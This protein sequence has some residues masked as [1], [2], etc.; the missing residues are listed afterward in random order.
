MILKKKNKLWNVCEPDGKSVELLSNTCNISEFLS[1]LLCSRG[2]T[3]PENAAS[4]LNKET[5]G[6]H[7]PFLLNDMD[8]AV[9]RINEALEKNEK[10][11]IYGDYDVDGLTSVSV[12]YLYLK[13]R[14]AF[15]DYYIPDRITEGYGLNISAMDKIKDS[16]TSLIITVDSGITAIEEIKY[17]T[18]FGLDVVITDHHECSAELPVCCAA[19]N[20][21]RNDCE[22]PFKE[23]AGVGVVFK[24][25]CALE[26]NKNLKNVLK[27]YSSLTA[28]GTIADVMPLE[29]ENRLIAHVGLYYLNNAPTV[30]IECLVNEIFSEK[31]K[32]NKG[33]INSSVIGFGIAP[34]INA[35]GRIGNAD[36]AATLLMS[37]TKAEA[38]RFARL[39]C[40]MNVQRQ[41]IE[42]DIFEEAL[43]QIESSFD[44]ENDRVIVLAGDGWHT[45]VIG[46]VASK[47]VEKYNLPTV[48]LSFDG[49]AGKGS[50]RSIKGFNIVE[51]FSKTKEYLTRFGGH[52]LAAGVSIDRKNLDGFVKAI[53][54]YAKTVFPDNMPPICLD[55]DFE[56]SPKYLN[57]DCAQEIEKLEPFG[58][59]NPTPVF[60]L[61][62]VYISESVPIT[63]GKHIR[64][65]L[66]KDGVKIN[67]MCF[68]VRSM[69][70]SFSSGLKVDCLINLS[71]NEF[72]NNRTAQVIIRDIDFADS[73]AEYLSSEETKYIN[74]LN[75]IVDKGYEIPCLN[76]FKKVFMYLRALNTESPLKLSNIN[77]L[78][79]SN[80][81]SEKYDIG[82]SPCDLN[83]IFDVL[84]EM[85]IIKVI[86][87]DNFNNLSVEILPTEGKVNLKESSILSKL[88][89]P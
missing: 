84:H 70:F 57:L 38:V 1:K 62:D 4:F 58:S 39:L 73:V 64:L 32:D 61:K 30:G 86:R 63:D 34:R 45:G 74:A 7:D 75:G 13:S 82:I 53:N 69:D 54:Q 88:E 24:L 16:G 52:E 37:E 55:A 79:A 46:I 60:Y 5:D 65:V 27:N 47:I 41:K 59:A 2:F 89:N 44:F 40:E 36:I 35:A 68:N 83:I 42:N 81:I 20:P 43:S 29:D 78:I 76:T 77:I 10:I 21:R 6:F 22:Y 12:L 15:V 48:M 31:S 3:S 14:K 8:K 66:E 71:V 33:K 56:I 67:A 72:R 17:V 25:I 18:S 85:K 50:A 28:I 80:L 49:D 87:Y 26:G 11:T 23:L 19:V 9:K 51:A